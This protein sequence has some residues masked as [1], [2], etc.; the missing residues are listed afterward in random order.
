MNIQ[1]NLRQTVSWERKLE[2]DPLTEN[3]ESALFAEPVRIL[4]RK[5]EGVR[6]LRGTAGYEL[7]Q[8]NTI[9]VTEDVSVGD[10]VDGEIVQARESLTRL[11]GE[12]VGYRLLTE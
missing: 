5:E 9:Y 7:R 11:G 12:T 8:G 2:G 3:W 1:R 10:R 4:A 6:E